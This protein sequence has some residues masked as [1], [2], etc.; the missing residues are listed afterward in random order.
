MN[1]SVPIP[2]HSYDIVIERGGLN[3]VGDWLRTLWGDKKVAIISDNRVAKL[4]ASIVEYFRACREDHFSFLPG[5]AR[6]CCGR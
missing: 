3:Q 5:E 6:P 1:V 4:Y 2:G